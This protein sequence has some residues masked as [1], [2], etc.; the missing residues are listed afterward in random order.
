VKCP[1]EH[2]RQKWEGRINTPKEHRGQ[3][4][5]GRINTPKEHRG[6][7]WEGKN[8]VYK[9][10]LT[11]SKTKY[12]KSEGLKNDILSKDESN[13]EKQ[14]RDFVESLPFLGRDNC[15]QNKPKYTK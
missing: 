5:E 11:S 13:Q 1:K 12:Y 2:H 3:Q 8:K 9:E 14:F 7:Q 10:K 6:Q 15:N 4:W